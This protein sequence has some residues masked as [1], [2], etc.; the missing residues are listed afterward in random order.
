L[1]IQRETAPSSFDR[2]IFTHEGTNYQRVYSTRADGACALHALFGTRVNNSYV[3]IKP[4]TV[5]DDTTQISTKQ[6]FLSCMLDILNTSLPLKDV[7]IN[8]MEEALTITEEYKHHLDNINKELATTKNH[9]RS[10]FT[11][12]FYYYCR[13]QLAELFSNS[14]K[15]EYKKLEEAF[16]AQSDVSEHFMNCFHANYNKIK[17][18]F[19]NDAIWKGI[20]YLQEQ[21]INAEGRRE[22]EKRAFVERRFDLYS[23]EVQ[24][25]SYYLCQNEVRLASELLPP[26]TKVLI[27]FDRFQG[28]HVIHPEGKGAII[29]IEH[30]MAYHPLG[31]HFSRLEPIQ[32]KS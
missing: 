15:S 25:S 21:Q 14:C 30:S 12:G 13:Q 6:N 4:G 16:F 32:Q 2:F 8:C 28:P 10:Q 7:L 9:I 23:R 17:E 11:N 29:A 27:F 1:N 20:L 18:D 26:E 31:Q 5:D 22:S 24:K 3:Y 19:S